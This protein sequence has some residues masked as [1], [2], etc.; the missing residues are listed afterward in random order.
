MPDQELTAA[1]AALRESI[2]ELSVHIP[3]GGIRGPLQRRSRYY[4]NLP[5]RW[6]SCRCEDNP[7]R[8]ESC[9]VSREKDLCAVCFRGTAGGV[10]RWSWVACENCREVNDAI[11]RLTGRR[12]FALGRHSLMNGIGIRGGA[13]PQVQ[14]EQTQRL[15]G[16]INSNGGLGDWR[17]HEYPRLASFFD[18]DSDVPLRLWQQQW[19]PSRQASLEVF[20]R[21]W[22]ERLP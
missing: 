12:P 3:C 2:T 11:E 9:D 19:P 1:D 16:F 18:P 6:Q 14:E 10:S 8:W 22:G 17:E 15:I 7:Q 5:I 20:K 13:S 4:P 21:L